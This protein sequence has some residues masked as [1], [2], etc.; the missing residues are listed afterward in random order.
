MNTILIKNGCLL[1]KDL[2]FTR[3]DLLIEDNVISRIATDLQPVADRVIDA[4]GRVVIP[5]LINAHGHSHQALFKGLTDN[6]PLEPWLIYA[7]HSGRDNPPRELYVSAAVGAIELLKTGTTS[8][9]DNPGFNP[10]DVVGRTEAILSAYIDVGMRAAVAPITDDRDVYSSFPFHLLPEVKE[11]PHLQRATP[12]IKDLEPQLRE[13]LRRWP[14]GRN[15][16]VSILL[17]PSGPARSSSEFVELVAGL[18]LDHGVGLHTHLLE[19]KAERL[20]GQQMFGKSTVDHLSDLG[21]LGPRTSFAHGVW[22]D[23]REIAVLADA[24]CSV[25]HNPISNL[26]VGS[27]VAPVQAMRSHKLNVALGQDDASA[28]DSAN[29]LEVM[30]Y[31]ALLHKLYGPYTSWLGAEDALDM[32]WSGGAKVLRQKVGALREGYLADL[33]ILSADTLFLMPKENFVAQLVFSELGSSVQTVIVDGRIVVEDGKVQTVDEVA[34]HAEA[35]EIV[36]RTYADLESR[37]SALAPHEQ[38]FRRMMQAVREHP[39][40]ITR[41]VGTD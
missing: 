12:T 5:G 41:F 8:I 22:L 7:V 39:L 31:A 19:T 36:D 21:W 37:R 23:D 6:L 35:Q 17:G 13:L 15:R 16:L 38:L 27:G 20:A 25:V 2:P 18:A 11:V 14:N 26:K 9:V 4:T 10:F 32:C 24:G 3:R 1:D 34:L 40:P 33:V 30:K 28:N 29:M